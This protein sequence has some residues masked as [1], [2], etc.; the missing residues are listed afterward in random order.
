MER[1]AKNNIRGGMKGIMVLTT[2]G[3]PGG[4]NVF[5]NLLRRSRFQSRI[6][7]VL[8]SR[9]TVDILLT[10]SLHVEPPWVWIGMP[11]KFIV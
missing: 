10:Y 1:C 3:C 9:H 4:L 6:L 2:V 5:S 7:W 8:R 11:M